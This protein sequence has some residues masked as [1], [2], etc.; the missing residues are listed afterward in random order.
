MPTEPPVLLYVSDRPVLSSLQFALSIEG[1][2]VADE[3]A[4]GSDPSAAAVLV[5]D[6]GYHGDG[7]GWLGV[8]RASGCSTAA[9]V[10]ATNPTAR[11]RARAIAAGAILVEK[12]LLG[13]ELTRALRACL[14]TQKAA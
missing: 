3:A 10:L 11:L 1:F 12:P 4:E 6:Q 13:D 14:P 2:A 8:L 7:L 9:V 5:V